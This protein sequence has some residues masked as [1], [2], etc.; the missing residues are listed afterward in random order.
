MLVED[1]SVVQHFDD[2]FEEE[3]WREEEVEIPR[4]KTRYRWLGSI[5][6]VCHSHRGIE[7]RELGKKDDKV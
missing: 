1:D 2:H 6:K 4:M 5:Q 7:G 3:Q